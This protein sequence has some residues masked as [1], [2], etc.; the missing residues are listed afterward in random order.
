MPKMSWSTRLL[1]L[2]QF[3]KVLPL[4]SFLDSGGAK[5]LANVLES[6]TKAFGV[7]AT[8]VIRIQCPASA[9][10]SV[11]ALLLLHYGRIVLISKTMQWRRVPLRLE[12]RSSQLR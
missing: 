8:D 5:W 10:L 3:H 12:N 11:Q 2:M 9:L 7:T 4:L 6:S 1:F